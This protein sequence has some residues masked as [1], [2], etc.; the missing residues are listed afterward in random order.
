MRISN[1]SQGD[2]RVPRPDLAA[3]L[4]HYGAASVTRSGNILCIVHEET[5]PSMSV[6][7][8]KQLVNCMSCGFAGDAFNIIMRKEGYDFKRAA[9]AS[10]QFESA[11]TDGGGE[12]VQSVLGRRRSGVSGRKG[13]P[14]S[15]KWSRP[16]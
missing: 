1:G 11:P 9:E 3:V 8:E 14:R 6:D 12:D 13:D 15:R 10:A 16:W 2:A 4:E 7:L 5:T